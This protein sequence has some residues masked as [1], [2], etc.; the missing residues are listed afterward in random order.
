MKPEAKIKPI[1]I[2]KEAWALIKDDYWMILLIVF[3][4]MIV[5]NVIPLIVIGPMMCG[6]LYVLIRRI[7][8]HPLVFEELFEG[9]KVFLPAFLVGLVLAVPAFILIGLIY[10][11]VIGIML[12]GGRMDNDELMAFFG[13]TIVV[14]LIFAVFM[15]CLHTLLM[16]AFPLIIDRKVSAI[17]A[18][19]MS[20]SAV[21]QNLSGIAGLYAVGFVVSLAGMMVFCIGL[22][23][24]LPLMLMS[25]AVA[26]RRL[27][28]AN[29]VPRP[30][31]YQG[32]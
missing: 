7:D 9:L 25:T 3:V 4:G 21:W 18:I 31:Y 28:P 29:E 12:A 6:I 5:A 17:Q 22:Y 16:F 8:G 20:A 23:L 2:Y 24:V 1:E 19:K 10:A 13:V 11:P 32:I 26:Y 27:F 15:V 30:N 14:E